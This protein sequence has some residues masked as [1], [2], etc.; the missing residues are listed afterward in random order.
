MTQ[1]RLQDDPP[2]DVVL[3]HSARARRI[4]LRVSGLDGRVTL[5][6]PNSVSRAEGIAF[7]RERRGWIEQAMLRHAA[8]QDVRIGTVLPVE[9][10][11]HVVTAATTRSARLEQD[12]ILVPGRR[13]AGPSVKAMLKV[14]ARDRLAE[15]VARY[16]DTIGRQPQRITLRDTRSRWGSCTTTGNLMFSWRLIL[17]PPEVLNYVAAHEVAHLKHMDHSSA[18]WAQTAA[19]FPDYHTQRAWLR[20]EGPSLHRWRF[21]D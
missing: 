10:R 21:D 8:P 6:L 16:S 11:G 1:V 18:F 5:T 12:R 15:A 20:S 14:L 7:A 4:S 9:G 3:R 17:A 19:L 13:P 2:I